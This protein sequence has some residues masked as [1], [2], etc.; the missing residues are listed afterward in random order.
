[1]TPSTPAPPPQFTFTLPAPPAPDASR[2]QASPRRNKALWLIGIGLCANALVML[3][4]H[5]FGPIP[6]FKLATPAFG[7]AAPSAG[8]QLLGARGLYMA[9]AQLGPNS[10]GLYLMDVD[11]GTICVYK[12]SPDSSRFKLMAARSYKY[13][14]FL[15]DLNNDPLTPASVQKLV[16]AQ[17]QRQDLHQKDDV[18][19]VDQAPKPDENMPDLPAANLPR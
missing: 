19:T 6:E 13:D 18:P 3:Y 10:F 8:G 5:A 12:V 11:S 1:M 9:P 14:R 7:Q 17:R 2:A 4:T 15:E 16:E